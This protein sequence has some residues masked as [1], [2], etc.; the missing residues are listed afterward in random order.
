[1]L[2]TFGGIVNFAHNVVF[3]KIVTFGLNV[4]AF[5]SGLNTGKVIVNISDPSLDNVPSNM[6]LAASPGIN[7][8]N[9]FF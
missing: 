3:K 2:T 9:G 7:Y 8:G 1:L 6:I 5:K 4:G